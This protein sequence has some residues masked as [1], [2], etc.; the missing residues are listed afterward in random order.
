MLCYTV[1]S[2]SERIQI[3][4]SRIGYIHLHHQ[5]ATLDEI[6]EWRSPGGLK[7]TAMDAREWGWGKYNG[8]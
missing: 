4:E 1:R 2:V 6:E 8:D 3:E 7:K 5:P